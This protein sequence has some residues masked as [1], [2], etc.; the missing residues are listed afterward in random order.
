MN[1]DVNI[2]IQKQKS[3]QKEICL[4]LR[5]I[6][7]KN[8]SQIHEEMY[9]GVPYYN[10]KFYIVALK[11]HVNFG[12]SIEHFSKEEIKE[13]KGSGKTVKVLELFKLEDINEKEIVA[14]IKKIV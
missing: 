8:F 5:K 13:F 3:P 4:V 1:K 2:Y 7:L 14:I 10:E 9:V 6:I 12:F 11:N